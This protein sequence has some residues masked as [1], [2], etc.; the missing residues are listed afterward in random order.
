MS[1]VFNI[2]V[3][4]CYIEQSTNTTIGADPLG[5]A[6]AMIV[7][8]SGLVDARSRLH[9]VDGFEVPPVLW[10]MTIGDVISPTV[11]LS[12]TG[13]CSMSSGGLFMTSLPGNGCLHASR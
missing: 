3:F 4:V 5:S 10:C 12:G 8:A 1:L 7:A 11:N 9:I 2:A 13:G 6:F